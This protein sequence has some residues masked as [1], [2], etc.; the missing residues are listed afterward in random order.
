MA[1]GLT[2]KS[3]HLITW[4]IMSTQVQGHAMRRS[5]G[6]RRDTGPWAPC[7]HLPIWPKA[8]VA[9]VAHGPAC[10]RKCPRI[11]ATTPSC[12]AAERPDLLPG[13]LGVL[14]KV[15]MDKKAREPHTPPARHRASPSASPPKP[16]S[17]NQNQ[18]QG[19]ADTRPNPRDGKGKGRGEEEG[20]RLA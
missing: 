6:E 10:S 2:R 7:V 3:F 8:L 12:V 14:K 16:T 19:R 5:M 13:P 1:T 17:R 4:A 20:M 18:S 11:S 9:Q 15:V